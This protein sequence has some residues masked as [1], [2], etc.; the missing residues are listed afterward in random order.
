[1]RSGRHG[2]EWIDT[3]RRCAFRHAEPGAVPEV[4][5]A[6]R[7]NAGSSQHRIG[8][9]VAEVAHRKASSEAAIFPTGRIT[10]AAIRTPCLPAVRLEHHLLQS[11]YGTTQ[12]GGAADC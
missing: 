4:L 10:S 11:R 12:G 3:F 5:H 9:D 6:R 1:G 2:L 8:H 7:E